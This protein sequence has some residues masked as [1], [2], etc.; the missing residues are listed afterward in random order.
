MDEDPHDIPWR[1]I[2]QNKEV[3]CEIPERFEKKLLGSLK[4]MLL[5]CNGLKGA[6][7]SVINLWMK[8]L[9]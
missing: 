1:N 6:R 5:F 7:K 4:H 8:E 3:Y 2:Y 9:G